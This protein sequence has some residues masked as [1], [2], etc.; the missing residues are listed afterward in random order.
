MRHTEL[1]LLHVRS[2]TGAECYAIAITKD[3]IH[4]VARWCKGEV[5]E[6]EYQSDLFEDL[7]PFRGIRMNNAIGSTRANVGDFVVCYKY[8]DHWFYVYPPEIFRSMYTEM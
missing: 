7:K 1:P 4:E 2:G 3:N 8:S 5:I 6:T